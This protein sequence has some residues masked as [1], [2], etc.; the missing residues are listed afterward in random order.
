MSMISEQVKRLRERAKRIIES[1]FSQDGAAQDLNDAADTIE[2]L[3]KKLLAAN[4]E[5]Y[6]QNYHK[7]YSHIPMQANDAYAKTVGEYLKKLLL[8]LW[9]EQDGFNAKRPF[10][11]GGWDYEIGAA[12]ICAGVIQGVVDKDGYVD[13]I[14]YSALDDAVCETIEAIF[15]TTDL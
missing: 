14:D 11:N 13:D 12:L 2:E 5:K 9:N 15:S 4:K 7:G 6:K 8:T 3:S 10:G 1:G